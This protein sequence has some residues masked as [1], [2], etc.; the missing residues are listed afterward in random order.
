MAI[1]RTG[2]QQFVKL[3]YAEKPESK[4]LSLYR[5]YDI[6]ATQNHIDFKFKLQFHYVM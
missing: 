3:K 2:C 4:F 6:A 1:F 5:T